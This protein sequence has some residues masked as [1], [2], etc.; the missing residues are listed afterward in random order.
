[1]NQG[2]QLEKRWCHLILLPKLLCACDLFT[3]DVQIRAKTKHL[4]KILQNPWA[5][6]YSYS[7]ARHSESI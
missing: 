3:A 4:L 7:A 6:S 2:H 1:M 5:K